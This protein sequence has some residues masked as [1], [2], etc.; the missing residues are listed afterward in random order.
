MKRTASILCCLLYISFNGFGQRYEARLSFDPNF[1]P[2]LDNRIYIGIE[3]MN[4]G[5]FMVKRGNLFNKS[6]SPKRFKVN[7][8]GGMYSK[9][10]E[11][12]VLNVDSLI[13]TQGN[14]IVEYAHP[15]DD[16]HTFRDT[17]QF[18]TIK[19]IALDNKAIAFSSL[20]EPALTV[21]YTN[22][23]IQELKGDEIGP[24]LTRYKFQLTLL[25][26]QWNPVSGIIQIPDYNNTIENDFIMFHLSSKDT[27]YVFTKNYNYGA[28][29]VANFPPPYQNAGLN[30]MNGEHIRV[31]V[32]Q[33]NDSL[34]TFKVIPFSGEPKTYVLNPDKGSLNISNTGTNGL[35][36]FNGSSGDHAV[37]SENCNVLASGSPGSDGTDGGNGGHGGSATIFLPKSF[38]PKL[39]A[40]KINNSGGLGGAGGWGGRGGRHQLSAEEEGKVVNIIFPPR[41]ASGAEGSFGLSGLAGN[42]QY[43]FTD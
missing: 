19:H 31:L 8:K 30:G 14:V 42:I 23:M 24:F 4:S 28:T 35:R 6:L 20:Y 25:N 10:L 18:P 3:Y 9:Y 29:Y 38:L 36:G 26:A 17:F 13:Q 1:N 5:G 22:G 37:A 11:C 7:V 32:E 21:T 27:S 12:I 33:F 39:H 2:V 41:A 15:L 34:Y 40:L 16:H 43:I